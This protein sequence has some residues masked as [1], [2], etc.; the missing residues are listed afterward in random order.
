MAI[1]SYIGCRGQGC[2]AHEVLE[3]GLVPLR[4]DQVVP[5]DLAAPGRR[6]REAAA[7]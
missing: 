6:Q 1:H 4:A 5:A 7:S 2:R 3:P